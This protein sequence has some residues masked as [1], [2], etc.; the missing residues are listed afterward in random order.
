MNKIITL[1]AKLF[2]KKFTTSDTYKNTKTTLTYY[3]F[4]NRLYFANIEQ[5]TV[6][7]K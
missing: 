5:I 2:G 7:L 4:M 3:K 1:L 6:E